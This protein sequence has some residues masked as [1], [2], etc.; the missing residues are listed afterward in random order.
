MGPQG[1]VQLP[2]VLGW[3]QWV[4]LGERPW[5]GAPFS[6]PRLQGLYQRPPEEPE[7]GGGWETPG[8][9]PLHSSVLIS[10]T[11]TASAP[12][13]TRF[14]GKFSPTAGETRCPPAPSAPQRPAPRE[15]HRTATG[16]RSRGREPFSWELSTQR[17]AALSLTSTQNTQNTCAIDL[18]TL[19]TLEQ[20]QPAFGSEERG[21]EQSFG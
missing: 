11:P 7:T 2:K 18:K 10:R 8:R 1:L 5:L 4:T 12:S 15:P 13:G 9:T 20:G 16:S 6:T 14:P 17:R 3:V 19:Q 21:S